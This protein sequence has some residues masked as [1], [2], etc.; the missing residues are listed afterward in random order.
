MI[1]LHGYGMEGYLQNLFDEKKASGELNLKLPAC[2]VII[3]HV[4]CCPEIF[5]K[6]MA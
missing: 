3:D 4:V 5:S 2:K 1:L 6:A